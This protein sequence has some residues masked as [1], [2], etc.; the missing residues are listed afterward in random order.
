MLWRPPYLASTLIIMAAPEG[1]DAAAITPDQM[2]E[3]LADLSAADGRHVVLEDPKGVHRLWLRDPDAEAMGGFIVFD[4]LF[5]VRMESLQRFYRRLVG[6]R[7]APTPRRLGL[8]PYRRDRL[9]RMIK[10]LDAREAGAS[11]RQIAQ[12]FGDQEATRWSATEW[13]NAK[14]RSDIVR[15]LKKAKSLVKGGYLKMLRGDP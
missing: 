11:L 4:D 13:K 12:A 5:F 10:A 15:L 6:L 3:L 14:A 7:A 2:G 8:T 1:F 9:I